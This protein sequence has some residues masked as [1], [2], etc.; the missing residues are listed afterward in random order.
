M[1]FDRGGRGQ[2]KLYA[3]INE[4]TEYQEI[5]YITI[6]QASYMFARPSYAYFEHEL[7][8]GDIIYLKVYL[9]GKAL[10]T[11]AS[12]LMYIGISKNNTMANVLT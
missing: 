10:D 7:N 11:G 8:K 4:A 1:I 3:K 5:G 12:A 2:S 6:N 9:L